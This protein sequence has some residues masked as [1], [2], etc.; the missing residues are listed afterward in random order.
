[1]TNPKRRLRFCSL[2]LVPCLLVSVVAFAQSGA[3]TAQQPVSSLDTEAFARSGQ[4]WRSFGQDL[5][6]ASPTN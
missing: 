6:F 2:T 3:T 5:P 1:M 4:V